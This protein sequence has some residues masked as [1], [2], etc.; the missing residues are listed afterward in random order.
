MDL[1]LYGRVLWRHRLLLATGVALAL[2][3]ALLAVVRVDFREGGLAFSYRQP[4]IWQAGTRLLVTQRGFPEGRTGFATPEEDAGSF[5]DPQRL[6]SLA[7]YYAQLVAADEVQLQVLGRSSETAALTA[8]PII[9]LNTRE[10]APFLDILGLAETPLAAAQIASR[11]AEVFIRY[12]SRRQA[13]ARIPQNERIVLQVVKR[14]LGVQAPLVVET[15]KKTTPA[16][17]FLAVLTATFG[18]IFGVE[19]VRGRRGPT[20]VPDESEREGPVPM[21]EPGKGVAS[22]RS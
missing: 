3:L 13:A 5:S 10:P 17:V 12:V 1:Q 4:E 7:S 2:A 8:A 14:P 18:F 16:F 19:N 22:G 6:S 11:G 21:R 20:P 9:D 15:R